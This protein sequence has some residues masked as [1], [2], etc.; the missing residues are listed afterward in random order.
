MVAAVAPATSP[1]APPINTVSADHSAS[2]TADGANAASSAN[3]F[4]ALMQKQ[5]G[6]QSAK[7][8]SEA[9]TPSLP[10]APE[11]AEV[12][13]IQ[14]VAIDLAALMPFLE[15]A[16]LLAKDANVPDAPT[17]GED[18][19]KLSA[20]SLSLPSSGEEM[21]TPAAILPAIMPS[22]ETSSADEQ[23]VSA[24]ASELLPQLGGKDSTQATL[25]ATTAI[26]AAAEAPNA[27]I[28]TTSLPG[29][30]ASGIVA[31]TEQDSGQAAF[32]VQL[33]AIQKAMPGEQQS[34]G[35]ETENADALLQPEADV[36]PHTNQTP[37]TGAITETAPPQRNST[38]QV[39]QVASP[40]GSSQWSRELGNQ[41]VWMTHRLENRAEMVLNP[42]QM[43]RIEVS[44]SVTGDQANAVF[45]SANPT[46]RDALEAAMPRL[47]E[48]LADAGIQLGQAQ[49]GAENARQFAQQEKNGDNFVPGR[50]TAFA[51]SASSQSMT[52][53]AEMPISLKAG[54]SL[55]DVFA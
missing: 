29:Q 48:I 27:E 30:T 40:V 11:D 16:G 9:G 5:M 38:T 51:D 19:S 43:G 20:E 15:A 26:I 14:S 45:T 49:V 42:P 25:P 24:Q 6:K 39:L 44:L 22:G 41:V 54:R 34:H 53:G 17:T 7:P 31:L 35:H 8:E 50:D 4:A 23:S 55:V 12:T 36:L 21:L 13:E 46:V 47:R 10:E 1:A 28:A 37:A 32:A 33:S 18:L 3:T 2:D 52:G